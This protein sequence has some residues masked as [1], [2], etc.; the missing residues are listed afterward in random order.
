MF[1]E[2]EGGFRVW[3][4]ALAADG[5]LRVGLT[6]GNFSVTVINSEDDAAH[7][8]V[9]VEESSIKDGL[10]YFDITESFLRTHGPGDYPILVEVLSSP[11]SVMMEVLKVSQ[12]D[13]DIKWSIAYDDDLSVVKLTA[14][15]VRGDTVV[16][17]TS[18]TATMYNQAGTL[19]FGPTAMSGPDA[20]GNFL[21][22]VT[23]ALI[24]NQSAYIDFSITDSSGVVTRRKY[25]SVAA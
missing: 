18:A 4:T 25:V 7:P 8:G 14:S 13:D 16:E 21:L 17:G 12:A 19:L 15:L 1:T 23:Q 22:Q 5:T 20:Q 3:F 6:N 2:I 10:Y 24:D 11:F 9:T